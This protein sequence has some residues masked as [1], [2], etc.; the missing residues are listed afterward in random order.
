MI[1]KHVRFWRAHAIYVPNFQCYVHFKGARSAYAV[2]PIGVTL[3]S[4]SH[5]KFWVSIIL[6]AY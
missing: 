3:F 6:N 5:L 2:E 4:V 1:D